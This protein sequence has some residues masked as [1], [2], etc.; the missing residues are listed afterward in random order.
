MPPPPH[1]PRSHRPPE[2]RCRR[3]RSPDVP[4]RRRVANSFGLAREFPGFESLFDLAD[5]F[6]GGAFRAELDAGVDAE[7]LH[8]GESN[9]KEPVHA[10]HHMGSAIHDVIWA[11]GAML[12]SSRVVALLEAGQFT[13]WTTWPVALTGRRGES[14]PGFA[15]FGVTGRCGPI[16]AS[17]SE[18]VL[19][20]FPAGFFPVYRGYL[21]D[22]VTWDGSDIFMPADHL[23]GQFVVEPVR[24]QMERAQITNVEFVALSDITVDPMTL[25]PPPDAD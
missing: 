5:P 24:S 9:V 17:R 16:E 19:Q 7:A 22:P 20:E 21:F 8:R 13:G 23:S 6:R 14:I 10:G 4:Q 11:G 18:L 25:D 3:R 15:G 2:S 12:V 1:R